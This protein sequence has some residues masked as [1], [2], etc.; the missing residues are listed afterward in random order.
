MC[1]K[2]LHKQAQPIMKFSKRTTPTN[3]NLLK[4]ITNELFKP[5][6]QRLNVTL[7]TF[8][9][10]KKI[11]KQIKTILGLENFYGGPKCGK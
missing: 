3:K 6:F 10:N 11:K 7:H 2:Y 8:F 1:F 4:Y 9:P 5:N